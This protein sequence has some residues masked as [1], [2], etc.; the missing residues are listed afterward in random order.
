V[1]KPKKLDIEIYNGR[2]VAVWY[3]CLA[4]PFD[5]HDSDW[6]RALEMMRMTKQLNEDIEA[7]KIDAM[8]MLHTRMEQRAY[9]NRY[10]EDGTSK[11]LEL[12][13]PPSDEI[14]I[15]EA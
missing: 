7:G 1:P 4:L 13:E 15:R 6:E 8:D 9:Q 14:T 10:N 12:Y 3:G 5:Q 11:P 2:V